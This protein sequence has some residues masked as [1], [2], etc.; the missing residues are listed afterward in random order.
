MSQNL[1]LSVSLLALV[2]FLGHTKGKRARPGTQ[3]QGMDFFSPFPG[4]V[5]EDSIKFVG[6]GER[7]AQ[8][9]PK[10]SMISIKKE[11]EQLP[12]GTKRFDRL[13]V[14]DL[15]PVGTRADGRSADPT[16]WWSI[17]MFEFADVE[18]RDECLKGLIEDNPSIAQD[19]F[20]FEQITE[21]CNAALKSTDSR[22][23]ES[24]NNTLKLLASM[25]EARQGEGRGM[26]HQLVNKPKQFNLDRALV[27]FYASSIPG[28]T[29]GYY[30]NS[31]RKTRQGGARSTNSQGPVHVDEFGN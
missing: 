5:A 26:T 10:I 8:Y 22:L 24:A 18:S 14:L 23:K 29:D 17:P 31:G 11:R 15:N 16:A 2:N 28:E 6:Y 19:V 20:T 12:D 25:A 7:F 13:R 30:T 3:E 9:A 1:N 27:L 4:S 21:G